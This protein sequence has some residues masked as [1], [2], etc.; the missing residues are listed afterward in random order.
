MFTPRLA[1]LFFRF[2][3]AT[4][5]RTRARTFTLPLCLVLTTTRNLVALPAA[6]APSLQVSLRLPPLTLPSL[7]GR[8]PITFRPATLRVN[9]GTVPLTTTP[10]AALGPRLEIVI[11]K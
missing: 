7:H 9:A 1:L 8:L 2:G 6:R 10:V 11:K 5:E 4:P 3:S